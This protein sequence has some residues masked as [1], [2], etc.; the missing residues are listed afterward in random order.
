[1]KSLAVRVAVFLL[2]AWGC[3][4][5]LLAQTNTP[6]AT[7]N[8]SST[9]FKPMS[10]RF[11]GKIASVD[12]QAKTIALENTIKDEIQMTSRTRII[13][14]KQPATFDALAAGQQVTGIKR[15]DTN[16]NWMALTLTVGDPRQIPT[17]PGMK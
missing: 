1:M 17:D 15:Q 13:K 12:A 5:L 7:N 2:A 8:P 9:V 10:K 11:S 4:S 16:G 3:G 6:A 14:N